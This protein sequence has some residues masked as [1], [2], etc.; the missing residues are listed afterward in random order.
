MAGGNPDCILSAKGYPG[1]PGFPE[2]QGSITVPVIAVDVGMSIVATED[3]GRDNRIFYPMQVQMDMFSISA[4]FASKEDRGKGNNKIRGMNIFNAWVRHYVEWASGGSGVTIGVQVQVPARNFNMIGFPTTGW[5]FDYAPVQL[6]DV[7]WVV[8]INF[9]GAAPV[10]RYSFLGTNPFPSTG[11]SY[12][13]AA[14]PPDKDALLFYPGYYTN[15]GVA[16]TG[17]PNGK[18]LDIPNGLPAPGKGSGKGG[19]LK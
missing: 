15:L 14:M 19:V 18:G 13:S 3:Q 9:D 4:I 8:T 1:V 7:N 5:S 6:T 2:T 16:G 17:P 10:G 12:H 11:S